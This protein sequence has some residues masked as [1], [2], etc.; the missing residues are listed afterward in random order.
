MSHRLSESLKQ[1]VR[2]A[3]HRLASRRL[4]VE[5]LDDRAL[6]SST[7]TAYLATDLV[8]DQA[9]VAP[10]TDPNLVNGW[11][12]A[13]NPNGGAFW[14]SSNGK[15]L[16]TLYTGDVNGNPL[17]KA[18]L[19]VSIPGGAPTGQVFNGTADFV[20]SAGGGS[21][22]ALFIFASES[23]AVTGWNPGVPP[24]PVSTG[25]QPAFQAVDGAI[26]K[27]IAL[28]N[29]G[30]GNFLYLADFHNNKIDVLNASFGK[31]TLAGNFTDPN[32]PSGYA[33]FNVAAI[34]GKLY[35]AYAKQ[36]A[37]AED[38]ITGK[39]LGFV[40]VFDL[41]GAF[42]QRLVSQG[43]LNAPW[44]MVLAP[45]G[46]GDFS[47]D[48]LVGN[49]GDGRIHA[50]DPANGAEVGTLGADKG[51]PLKI[52]GLW[53]LAFGNGTSAGS[54]TTL[55]YA[56]GPEEESHGL[57]GKITAN[58]AGTSPVQATL[59]NGDLII[60]GSR[61]ND[62]IDVKLDKKEQQIDVTANG[63]LVGSFDVTQVGT[64]RVN[65]FS[66]DDHIQVSNRLDV[67]TI[68]DGGAGKDLLNGGGGSNVLIGGPGSDVLMG[69]GSRDILI[70]GTGR[71]ILLGRGSD[72]LLIGGSTNYDSD[73]AALLQILDE[74]TSTD[75]YALRVDKLRNGTGGVPK[76]DATTVTDDSTLD[77]LM[78]GAGLDWFFKGAGDL[79][80]GKLAVE[81][82]N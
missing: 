71:D 8:S 21:G 56:A 34:N 25:A 1:F 61:D 72:D 68:L 16:S 41:N 45:A 17:A 74:W 78:G 46:F 18:G 13:I 55:Y 65:G 52:D 22:P 12:I 53:G 19:E 32:L 37:D 33:P 80:L 81:L 42:Q 49:F 29:N 6:P 9:G 14:V 10:I 40:D 4:L 44:A 51:H 50:Y 43:D 73:P 70:G 30:A 75:S 58:V 69:Q 63:K 5:L 26:Y 82:L 60:T 3:R 24:P 79:V 59:T 48:L 67:T 20:V 54:S 76:L 57:F 35:V 23:G 15:D 2:P 64:I 38:E 77:L 47:G 62:H 31:T 11:G 39:G 36:D 27:G 7:A 66:G 28:A